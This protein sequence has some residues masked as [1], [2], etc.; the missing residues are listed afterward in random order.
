[1]AMACRKVFVNQEYFIL[2]KQ[3]KTFV[4]YHQQALVAVKNHCFYLYY[5][6]FMRCRRSA[7]PT[8]ESELS[9]IAT[10]ASVGLNS[11]NAAKGMAR[12][13]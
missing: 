6:I 8:T 1:M 10:A 5:V 13:L 3:T 11:P 9:A 2:T 7:L 4:F 12:A